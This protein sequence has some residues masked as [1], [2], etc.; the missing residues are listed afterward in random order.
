MK[1]TIEVQ[2]R[3]GM[4]VKIGVDMKDYYLSKGYTV[5]GEPKTKATLL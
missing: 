5:V 1:N 4:P 3:N 2:I